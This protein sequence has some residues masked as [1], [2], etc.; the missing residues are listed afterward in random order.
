MHIAQ[1]SHIET[2]STKD[3]VQWKKLVYK[4]EYCNGVQRKYNLN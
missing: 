2:R 1:R 3:R 4:K